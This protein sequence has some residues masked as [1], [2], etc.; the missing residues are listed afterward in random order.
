[1]GSVPP[2]RHPVDHDPLCS[3]LQ[4]GGLDQQSRN[5]KLNENTAKSINMKRPSDESEPL[6]SK[7]TRRDSSETKKAFT[8]SP[9]DAFRGRLPF[10]RQP[11]EVG[12]FSL[13]KNRGFHDD[14]RQLRYFSPPHNIDFDLRAGYKEFVKRN[15][16]EK[17]GLEHLLQWTNRHKEKFEIIQVQSP[18]EKSY[19]SEKPPLSR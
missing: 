19:T 15:E 1:M 3:E 17:E 14:K 12:C 11:V 8:V 4:N 7:K 9:I 2:A 6:V 10:Y 13:D 5:V 18:T 16:D